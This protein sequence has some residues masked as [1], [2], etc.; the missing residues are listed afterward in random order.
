MS[1]E[2]EGMDE[3]IKK[4]ENIEK[5]IPEEFDSLKMTVASEILEDVI[6]NTPVNKNPK[7]K[8]SGNLKRGWKVRDLGDSVEIYNDVQSK[9]EYYAWDVEYGH[10]TRAGMNLKPSKRR[11]K[12]VKS[13]DGK[14]LFVPG[15]FMLRNAMKK[16]KATL[17]KEGKKILDDLMGGR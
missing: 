11:R 3:L 5:R 7:A 1:F 10:R 9:G 2:F 13:D 14:I 12:S 16:G 17:D 15:K 6:E 4:L 8:T